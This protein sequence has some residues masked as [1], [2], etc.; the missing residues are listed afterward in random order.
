MARVSWERVGGHMPEQALF[1]DN[2]LVIPRISSTDD[3][4]YRCTATNIAG[5][6]WRQITVIVRGE[7]QSFNHFKNFCY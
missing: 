4:V 2:E 5:E 3:G 6:L 7:C 1:H